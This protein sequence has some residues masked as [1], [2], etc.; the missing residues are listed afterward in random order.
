MSESTTHNG[1][2]PTDPIIALMFTVGTVAWLSAQMSPEQA[3]ACAPLFTALI[4]DLLRRL[5][6]EG[7]R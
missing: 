7:G 6:P 2:I 4:G 5:F 3:T 1:Q